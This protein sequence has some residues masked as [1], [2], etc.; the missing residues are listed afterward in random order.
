MY[1]P[2]AMLGRDRD[3][4]KDV[5]TTVTARDRH[6]SQSPPGCTS[7]HRKSRLLSIQFQYDAS[8]LSSH[9]TQTLKQKQVI[10]SHVSK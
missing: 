9:M 4:N 6:Q 3:G 7:Q 8:N 1:L 2:L 5:T 10:L